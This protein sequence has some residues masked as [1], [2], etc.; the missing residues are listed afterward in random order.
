MDAFEQTPSTHDADG[1]HTL[2][3]DPETIALWLALDA[4]RRSRDERTERLRA[5][6]LIGG[7]D[8]TV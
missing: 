6:R 2:Q 1:H 7:E 3:Q 4:D 5:M 8:D